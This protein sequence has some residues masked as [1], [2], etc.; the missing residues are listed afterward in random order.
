MEADA[1]LSHFEAVRP[2]LYDEF[3]AVTGTRPEGVV[4]KAEL[5]Y[6]LLFKQEWK[7]AWVQQLDK[8]KLE[9]DDPY[10][11]YSEEEQ[12]EMPEVSREAVVS[13]VGAR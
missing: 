6:T 13:F 10:W 4:P 8:L 7:S 2:P 3:V 5:V 12:L 11:L 9:G 1:I